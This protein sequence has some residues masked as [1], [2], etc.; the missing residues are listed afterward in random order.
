M[1]M[2]MLEAELRRAR[3]RFGFDRGEGEDARWFRDRLTATLADPRYPWTNANDPA[4]CAEARTATQALLDLTAGWGSEE[5][6]TLGFDR[7]GQTPT[8][9]PALR[10][11]PPV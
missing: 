6:G 7:E 3:D 1:L 8:P 10:I 2:Q 9:R 11:V 4:W 5:P